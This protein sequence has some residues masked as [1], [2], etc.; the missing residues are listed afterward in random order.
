MHGALSLTAFNFAIGIDA[1]ERR[2]CAFVGIRSWKRVVVAHVV[3]SDPACVPRTTSQRRALAG[4]AHP[5]PSSVIQHALPHI[6][7]MYWRSARN[8]RGTTARRH[9]PRRL[10]PRSSFVLVAGAAASSRHRAPRRTPV[11]HP[12]GKNSGRRRHL[13]LARIIVDCAHSETG[14]LWQ[15]AFLSRIGTCGS[16]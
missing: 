9:V 7:T 16:G 8:L 11:K 10:H 13:V 2:T 14:R 5:F 6:R 12:H 4:L 1:R 3:R 15:R